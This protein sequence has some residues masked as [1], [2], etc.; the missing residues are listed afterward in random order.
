MPRAS[1]S[2]HAHESAPVGLHPDGE[3]VDD[4]Q[5]HAGATGGGLSAGQLLV[6]QPL[7][8]AVEVHAVGLRGG[9]LGDLAAVGPRSAAGHPCQLLPC[10]SVSAHHV[11]KSSQGLSLPAAVRAIGESAARE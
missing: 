5:R 1:S 7:Q 2:C 9:E 8:P 3:V 10:T 6:E 11:A 4:P